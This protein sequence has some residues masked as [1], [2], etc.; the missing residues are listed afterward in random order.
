MPGAQ[1]HPPR[2]S[3]G[4]LVDDSKLKNGLPSAKHETPPEVKRRGDGLPAIPPV[5]RKF[6]QEQLTFACAPS[7]RRAVAHQI[8]LLI[9]THELAAVSRQYPVEGIDTN[10]DY[11]SRVR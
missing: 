9:G 3:R 1:Y 7:F 5:F 6:A 8:V 10:R 2:V 4:R 11:V